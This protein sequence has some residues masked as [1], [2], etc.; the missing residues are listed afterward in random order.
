MHDQLRHRL[1]GW[2]AGIISHWPGWILAIALLLALAAV[3]VTVSQLSF[4]S[5]RNDLI[6]EDIDWNQRFIHWRSL[7]PGKDDII[8][9]VETHDPA[10]GAADDETAARAR[11]LVNELA[12]RLEA[13]DAVVEVVWGFDQSA[14]HPR[15]VRLLSMD[16]FEAQLAEV[17]AAGPL[18]ESATPQALIRQG[19]AQ[20]DGDETDEDPAQAQAGLEAFTQLIR[21]FTHRMQTQTDETVDL[22]QFAAP[23]MSPAEWEYLAT[24]NQRFLIMQVVPRE[25]PG[26]L[27]PIGRSIGE[28]RRLLRE[29][30]RD[31]PDVAFGTTGVAVVETDETA[32]ATADSTKASILAVVLITLLL[33]AAFHSLRMPLLLMIAL[34]IG[35]AWS[36][37]FLTLAVGHLQVISVIFA[38][39]LL[40]LGVAFG[41]HLITGFELHRHRHPDSEEGFR[42]TMRETFESV[43]PG[44][45]TGAFTT[46]A[47]FSTTLLTDFRGV[48]EMGLIAAGGILLCLLAMV[49]VFPALLRL[50]KRKH[51]HF[52]RLESRTFHVFEER[53]VSPFTRRPKLTLAIAGVI[54]G[55]SLVAVSQLRFDYNLVELMP[56]N[57]ESVE[58]QRRIADDGEQSIWSAV[59]VANSLEEARMLTRQYQAMGSVDGVG[60]IGMLFPR[61]EDEKLSLIRDVQ[62]QVGAAAEQ[63]LAERVPETPTDEPSLVEQL[64]S[65]QLSLPFVQAQLPPA[66]RPTLRDTSAAINEFVTTAQALPADERERRLNALQRDYDRWRE[67]TA[68]L[69]SA[70]LDDGPMQ[71]TDLPA[72]AIGAYVAE[73]D[74]QQ[75]FVLEVYPRLPEDVTDPLNPRVLGPFVTEVQAV[76]PEATGAMVQLYLSGDLIWRSYLLAGGLALS[77]VLVLVWVDF[78]S[79]RDAAL[80]LVPVAAGFAVTFAIMWL[81]GLNINPANIMVLPLMFGIGV[82]AGVHMLHR[83]RQDPTRRP[84]GLA[85]GTGK[86]I[87]LTSFTTMI[88]FGSLM[89]AQ[90]RGIAGIGFVLSVGI[91]MTLLACWTIVPA[92]LELRTRAEQSKSKGKQP[93]AQPG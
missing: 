55:L 42:A 88:G 25:D 26:A 73:R 76:D 36:F 13:S 21:G 77:A 84:L 87:T 27:S 66:L 49:S 92:W 71:L 6:S 53:W 8:I 63:A 82:D 40:G 31:Y 41:I 93:H 24:P 65:L 56:H 38:V 4:Q 11:A 48:A 70:T 30:G 54:T 52:V 69:V 1:L 68:Q 19:L 10:T 14:V 33:V 57:I 58:W 7:F 90:H 72:E 62:A 74:G 44:I 23:G 43:G 59:S 91:G 17:G 46:A 5:N 83:Y 15:S 64:R 39:I 86:G 80:T 47:A 89:L 12:E 60:G 28:V 37:G 67:Q 18:L 16:A 81:V 85:G 32:A 3:A 2:W 78:R 79:I 34:M 20:A 22:M 75:W 51:K 61:D 50:Y 35:I 9:I 45:V 29:V